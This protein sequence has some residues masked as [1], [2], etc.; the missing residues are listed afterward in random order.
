[1][2]ST[3]ETRTSRAPGSCINPR[4]GRE[5]WTVELSQRIG[6]ADHHALPRPNKEAGM[7][8]RYS[9]ATDPSL[10]A[11]RFQ[12]DPAEAGED[13][14]NWNVTPTSQVVV[15]SG[16]QETLRDRDPRQGAAGPTDTEDDAG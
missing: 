16:V 7:C 13:R 3:P 6:H 14:P 4:P 5:R 2:A 15:V 10:L 11:E 12:A 1:M 9:A 8:G